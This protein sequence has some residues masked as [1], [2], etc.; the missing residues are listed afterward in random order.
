MSAAPRTPGKRVAPATPGTAVRS[1]GAETIQVVARVRPLLQSEKLD[2]DECAVQI[3]G[4]G[5]V[6][7]SPSLAGAPATFRL[8]HVVPPEGGQEAMFRVVQPQLEQALSGFNT[9]VFAY[10]QTG[11]GKT[12]T[13]LGVDMWR[14]AETDSSAALAAAAARESGAPGAGMADAVS[15]GALQPGTPAYEGVVDRLMA[16]GGDYHPDWGLIPR[17]MAF[18]FC[19]LQASGAGGSGVFGPGGIGERS[20]GLMQGAAGAAGAG[21]AG[22]SAGRDGAT[23]SQHSSPGGF[24]GG[25]RQSR[26]TSLAGGAAGQ[27]QGGAAP[28]SRRLPEGV[29]VTVTYLEIYNE[30]VY[31][32]L[33]PDE[34]PLMPAP[35]PRGAAGA[36]QRV[37]PASLD[38]VADPLRGVC[39]PDAVAV[40]VTNEAEVLA[41]LW[42]GAR[43]RVLASTDM[44]EHS[45]RSHTIWQ[46]GI[47]RTHRRSPGGSPMRHG[48]P[49]RG[50]S[51][52]GRGSG[53]GAGSDDEDDEGGSGLVPGSTLG[54][55][56]TVVSRSKVSLVDLA[57]SEKIRP[58]ALDT[59]SGRRLTELT[60]INQSL[61]CLG[62]CVRALAS[63]SRTHVPY[64]DSKLTRL[65]QDSLGGNCKTLFVVTISPASAHLEETM[66]TLHFA[67]RAK[68]VEVHAERNETLDDA[69][70]ARRFKAEAARLRRE[71]VRTRGLVG[72]AAAGTA[73]PEPGSATASEVA[74]LRAEAAAAHEE[75]ARWREAA[76]RA[77][78]EATLARAARRR[79]IVAASA[80]AREAGDADEGGAS[81]A[82]RAGLAAADAAKEAA[83][84]RSK[85]LSELEDEVQKRAA[86]LTRHFELM[87]ALPL[88]GVPDK[89]ASP[90]RGA[91]QAQTP[92]SRL[93]LLEGQV[94]RLVGE[95]RAARGSFLSDVRRLQAAAAAAEQEAEAA[96]HQLSQAHASR[97]ADEA[98]GASGRDGPAGRAGAEEEAS[99]LFGLSPEEKT[100]A[101]ELLL[102]RQAQEAAR[103]QWT[104]HVDKRTQRSYWH[105]E[106]TGETQ[107]QRPDGW[108][109]PGDAVRR[110]EMADVVAAHKE[111]QARLLDAVAEQLGEQLAAIA[112][113]AG[114]GGELAEALQEEVRRYA[115]ET[116]GALQRQ[117]DVLA[118]SLGLR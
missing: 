117:V 23:H 63:R 26:R 110:A 71:L 16:Y 27:G 85:R 88:V 42:E 47:E 76:A 33:C 111:Q 97:A 28:F 74:E 48:S 75:A 8:D 70:L 64:R 99:A 112:R 90:A 46:V 82:L 31:D 52:T 53:G 14:L 102:A 87:R 93:A 21:A 60:A 65:L 115:E 20:S 73:Q 15:S 54:D 62:N 10:G 81:R 67:D 109:T 1:P 58:H 7:V 43:N 80:A 95:V 69:S 40:P 98:A 57:G 51:K 34:T 4:S 24:H 79:V 118:A 19:R 91:S 56:E 104:H 45:S 113:E 17:A 78:E 44:N 12:H 35:G 106:G 107:W 30:K 25:G 22:G 89:S 55:A 3:R 59:L 13:M 18:L 94:Q 77:E 61:S 105:N 68:R 100:E 9:T 66:S 83:D 114:E 92:S 86:A 101:A 50:S 6:L 36:G 39:V 29:K 96:A 72:R 84:R 41:L 116:G 103:S 37:G 38:I 11:T 49:S 108:E 5:D 32:L 2:G